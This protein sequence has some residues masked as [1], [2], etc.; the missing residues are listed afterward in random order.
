MLAIADRLHGSNLPETQLR[1]VMKRVDLLGQVSEVLILHKLEIGQI[2]TQRLA[3]DSGRLRGPATPAQGDAQ[4]DARL[5]A[6][7]IGVDGGAVG[8]RRLGEAPLAEGGAAARAPRLEL[9]HRHPPSPA[10]IS[11]PGVDGWPPQCYRGAPAP[12]AAVP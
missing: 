1:L 3:K 2:A 10:D 9:T 4:I 5:E 7:G 6:P 12:R 11:I 8:R